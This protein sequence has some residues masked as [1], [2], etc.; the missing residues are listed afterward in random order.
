MKVVKALG[1]AIALL[2]VVLASSPAWACASKVMV[3]SFCFQ[4][5]AGLSIKSTKA[6]APND[7]GESELVVMETNSVL[8]R[9]GA[10]RSF[11][12]NTI[13][14]YV[15]RMYR[16]ADNPK[17]E[18]LTYAEGQPH[19]LREAVGTVSM[20]GRTF[21][22]S[23]ADY[24]F[25]PYGAAPFKR[26][27]GLIWGV[28]PDGKWLLIRWQNRGGDVPLQGYINNLVQSAQIMPPTS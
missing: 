14:Q 27:K 25:T 8:V 17:R 2:V 9:V 15:D 20:A 6:V 3:A 5:P 19:T 12:G 22:I 16:N 28:L 18:L 1:S 4:V 7:K 10:F 11:S 23:V 26:Q 24:E 21:A 13:D